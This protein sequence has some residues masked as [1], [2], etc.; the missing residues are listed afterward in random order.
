MELNKE[1]KLLCLKNK[2]ISKLKTY[3]LENNN[4]YT[5]LYVFIESVKNQYTKEN[6]IDDANVLEYLRS[7]I[8]S[9]ATR[10]RFNVSDWLFNIQN[11]R[12][13]NDLLSFLDVDLIKFNELE[14]KI[15]DIQSQLDEIKQINIYQNSYILRINENTSNNI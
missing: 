3:L 9:Y 2:L 10:N 1:S 14:E 4:S 12:V 8:S 13:L 7:C 11:P 15:Q 6:N 5:E